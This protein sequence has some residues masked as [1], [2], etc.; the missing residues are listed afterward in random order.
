MADKFYDG[1]PNVN[2]E[3]NKLN[4][5]FEKGPYNALPLTGGALSGPVSSTSTL[6]F[7]GANPPAP[8][9]ATTMLRGPTHQTGLTPSLVAALGVGGTNGLS[10]PGQFRWY[11]SSGRAAGSGTYTRESF[12]LRLRAIDLQGSIESADLMVISG[13]GDVATR[14]NLSSSARMI[15]SMIQVGPIPGGAG[16]SIIGGVDQSQGKINLRIPNSTTFYV[17]AGAMGAASACSVNVNASTTTGRSINAGGTINAGGADYA[18]Y[19]IK[20]LLCGTIVPGQIVG[21]DADGRLTD[22]WDRAIAF[23]VKSTNP[24]MVGGDSW[25]HPLGARPQAPARIAPVTKQELVSPAVP[26]DE[27][28][29]AVAID[30]VYRTI[31]VVQGD[32]DAEW[33]S[34]EA[35]HVAALA[36]FEAALERLRQTVDRIAFAGQVPVNVMDARP[37]QYI[38]PIKDGERIGAIAVDEDDMTLKQYMRSIGKVIAIEGDGRARIIVKVA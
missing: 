9:D 30:A 25:G 3:L 37:G 28:S 10:Y 24:C 17:S 18:E 29:G 2:E 6:A 12:D 14:G 13:A 19:L 8:G 4:A 11:T 26:A 20:A 32:T 21:I 5:A 38:V 34:K 16:E 35:T 31:V 7:L 1:M 15:S 23:A 33:A 36:E 22:K 27:V